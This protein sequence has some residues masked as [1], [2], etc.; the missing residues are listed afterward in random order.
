VSLA[1]IICALLEAVVVEEG[2]LTLLDVVVEE[3]VVYWLE[4]I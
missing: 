3:L 1:S 2:L 4:Q